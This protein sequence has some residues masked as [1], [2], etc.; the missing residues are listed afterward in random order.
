MISAKSVK[1]NPQKEYGKA[2]IFFN[3]FWFRNK[4]CLIATGALILA[5]AG[6]YLL[7]GRKENKAKTPYGDYKIERPLSPREPPLEIP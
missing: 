1:P 3:R 5:I 2:A 6:A 7:F 4:F